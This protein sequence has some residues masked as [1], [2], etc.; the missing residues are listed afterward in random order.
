MLW[1][2]NI[3]IGCIKIMLIKKTNY[4]NCLDLN[5]RYK[6][7]IHYHFENILMIHNK[8]LKLGTVKVL[9]YK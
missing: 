9:S 1:V 6:K 8:V 7:I 3:V 2:V 5:V 4:C